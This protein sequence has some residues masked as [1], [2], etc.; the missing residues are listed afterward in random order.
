MLNRILIIIL[1]IKINIFTLF[2]VQANEQFNFNVT[3]IEILEDGNKVIGSNGGEVTTEDGLIISA[4]SFIYNKI[5]NVLNAN[6][7]V[8]IRDDINNYKIFS[9][10]IIYDKNNETI[11][12]DSITK[13]E[14]DSRYEIT[15]N[16]VVF[17]KNKNILSSKSKTKLIDKESNTLY[18]LEYLILIYLMKF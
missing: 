10:N 14:I 13:A 8:I 4:D 11:Y 18:N 3:E 12:S 2:A 17:L 15:S 7:N 16:N 9:N 1:I 6:G 5:E